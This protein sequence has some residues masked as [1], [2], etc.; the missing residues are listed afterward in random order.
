[1]T[2]RMLKTLEKTKFADSPIIAVAANPGA[3]EQVKGLSIIN[4]KV[5]QEQFK[6]YQTF[7]LLF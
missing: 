2:K 4:I 6:S 1:M 5:F 7:K 3:A